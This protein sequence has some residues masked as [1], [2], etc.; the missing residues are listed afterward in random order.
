[1][2]KQFLMILLA[3]AVVFGLTNCEEQVGESNPETPTELSTAAI[4]DALSARVDSRNVAE[5]FM[6]GRLGN[7]QQ[8]ERRANRRRA[9]NSIRG[10]RSESHGHG[11]GGHDDDCD[12]DDYDWETCANITETMNEDGSMTTVIDYGEGCDEYGAII[13][14]TI[15]IIESFEDSTGS[16]SYGMVFDNYAETYEQD[17]TDND[18]DYEPESFTL[19]GSFNEQ[20]TYDESNDTYSETHAFDFTITYADGS[21][22]T[23][24]GNGE[25]RETE[26]RFEVISENFNGSDSEGNTFSGEVIETLVEDFNCNEEDVF[27]FTS[28]VEEWVW[29][30]ETVRIDYGD[31]TCDNIIFVTENGVTEEID[32]S[33]DW[34]E[35]DEED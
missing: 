24:A 29:N 34:D 7:A 9:N 26:D 17:T 23:I 8:G 14:G 5:R 16:F 22:E 32:L 2:K 27:T 21:S 11:D 12:D 33:E 30:G 13:S 18:D 31:G 35:D 1:M 28:G 15:T 4:V 19:N 25:S 20:G 10:A 3:G 6:F